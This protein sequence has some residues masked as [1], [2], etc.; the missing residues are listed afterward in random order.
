MQGKLSGMTQRIRDAFHLQ[1]QYCRAAGSP[2]TADV[3]AA[4]AD[5]LD[6]STRTGGRIL[7]WAGDAIVDALPLR[8]A[9]GLNA[10]VRSGRDDL[11]ARLYKSRDVEAHPVLRQTLE[12]WDDWL[13]PWLDGP[14]QTNEVARSGVLWPGMQEIAR[15][16][17]PDMEWIEIG[18]SAGLNLNMDRFGYR[19]GSTVSGDNLSA[20]QLRPAWDGPSVPDCPVHVHDRVG[21]DLLPLDASDPII[22]ERML[23]YIWPDQAERLA[24]AEAA[25]R[26]AQA[27]PPPIVKG[28]VAEL[29]A[30]L[31]AEPQ[32]AGRTRVIFHSI[33][34]Q[35]FP[36]DARARVTDLI[37]AAGARADAARP[38]AWLA[39]EFREM[40]AA[41]AQLTLRCWPGDGKEELLAHAH[42]HG[43]EINWVA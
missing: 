18:S 34:L 28:D 31:L 20:V 6:H 30:P 16:F 9:G 23:A 13:L 22:V 8:I 4:L 7:D 37:Q 29:L 42:P 26:V 36:T 41:K 14:P 38:L 2:L 43:A 17:G 24:R 1:A 12:K 21:I 11:L 3:V 35:Y 40:G 33:A 25:I 32:A 39:M 10:L 15:R 19:L 27:N 5:V